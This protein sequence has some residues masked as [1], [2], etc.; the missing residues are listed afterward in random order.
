M[1]YIIVVDNDISITLATE[2]LEHGFEIGYNLR[3]LELAKQGVY[4]SDHIAVYQPKPR[5]GI[6]GWNKSELVGVI[7]LRDDLNWK[8]YHF[9]HPRTRSLADYLEKFVEGRV[10]VTFQALGTREPYKVGDF[11]PLNGYSSDIDTLA[12]Y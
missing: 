10:T 8:V 12:G 4:I 1:A 2:L 5:R 3:H 7:D 11:H 9:N 6:F